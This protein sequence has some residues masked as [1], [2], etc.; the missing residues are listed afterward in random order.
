MEIDAELMQLA[1]RLGGGHRQF[2]EEEEAKNPE[3]G[4]MEPEQPETEE[5]SNSF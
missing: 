4:E 3:E 5:H 1:N 2:A